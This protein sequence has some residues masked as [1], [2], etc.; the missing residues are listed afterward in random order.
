MLNGKVHQRPPV[1]SASTQRSVATQQQISSRTTTPMIT[2][3]VRLVRG[4]G[5]AITGAGLAGTL[6]AYSAGGGGGG[7]TGREIEGIAEA[8]GETIVA[9]A[10]ILVT[11]NTRMI[12]SP[13][14]T[15]SPAFNT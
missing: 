8:R 12:C 6:P 1:G 13:N 11:S 7:P 4:A 15:T 3:V 10:S 5:A 14:E 9:P 2:R